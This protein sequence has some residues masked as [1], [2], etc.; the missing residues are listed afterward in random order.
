MI[1][2]YLCVFVP[3]RQSQNFSSSKERRGEVKKTVKKS[4]FAD[5]K[6]KENKFI[7]RS[8]SHI[9][10]QITLITLLLLKFAILVEY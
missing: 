3:F 1:I 7:I 2:V 6:A 10:K 5:R 4:L 8:N 9:N